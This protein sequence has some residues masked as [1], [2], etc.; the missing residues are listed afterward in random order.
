MKEDITIIDN[1]SRLMLGDH[2][3]ILAISK[4]ESLQDIDRQVKV[5]AIL[6]GRTE[7]E[8]LNLPIDTYKTLA[9]RSRFLEQPMPEMARIA[10]SYIVGPYK[11]VP[12]TDFRKITTAQYIDFQTFHEAGM[13]DHFV[14]IL[15]CLLVPSGKK[16]NQDY[17][18]IDVQKAI[19]EE[20]S[21]ADGASLYAF[22]LTS[23]AGSIKDMLTYSRQEAMR[24]K[25]KTRREEILTKIAAAEALLT[26]GAG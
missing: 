11:L 24:L 5:I 1:Y 16:Y 25:D 15:S 21:V 6:T 3:D 26:N 7:D 17:D 4:D 8:I 9:A 10:K 22:F 14:E 18:I 2:Q 23:S 20:M 13:E 19:R 12:V